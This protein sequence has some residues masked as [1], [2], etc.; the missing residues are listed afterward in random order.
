MAS[1][2]VLTRPGPAEW[3]DLTTA[4]LLAKMTRMLLASGVAVDD[5]IADKTRRFPT[6]VA[7]PVIEA[8]DPAHD[9]REPEDPHRARLR[10]GPVKLPGWYADDKF[11]ADASEVVPDETLSHARE[12]RTQ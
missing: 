7:F 10:R 11:P 5:S 4:D 9:P 8:P 1:G 3:L 2:D 12:K 6:G